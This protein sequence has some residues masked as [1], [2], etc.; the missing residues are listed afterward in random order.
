MQF[1]DVLSPKKRL[2]HRVM[3]RSLKMG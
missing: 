1:R 3:E 2:P